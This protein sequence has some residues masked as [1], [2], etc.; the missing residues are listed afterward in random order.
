MA[1]DLGTMI[2][3][4]RWLGPWA[5]D[6]APTR[7]RR[8]EETLEAGGRAMRIA[9]H[10]PRGA[11]R[12]VW[13]V[14]PG[15]HFLGPGDPRLD[16]FCRVLAAAGFVVVAPYLPDFLSLVIAERASADLAVAF[17]RAEEIARAASLP[18]PALFSISF[19]SL[20]AAAVAASELGARARALVLFGGFCDFAET[21][22][23]SITGRASHEGVTLEVEHDP[24]NAPVVHL[25]MLPLM[26]PELD[27]ARLAAAWRAMV[28]RTWGK[29]E[30][31]VGRAREP[32]ALDV[33]RAH[34]LEG[35]LRE[36]FLVGCGLAPGGEAL[37]EAALS[38]LG[39][40]YA[41]ADPRPHLARVKPPVA[42]VHGR[43][44]DV[45][46]YFEAY[47]IRAALPAGHPHG[48]H[49]TGMYGHTGSALPSPRAL[50]GELATLARVLR[51]LAS[52]RA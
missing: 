37:V 10:E 45:I 22:R 9:V 31:K 2:A 12:A 8:R 29:P 17:E 48:L 32:F 36:A 41:W 21:V 34:G 3:L 44:D 25:H 1:G 46:P 5:G 11:A 19:G 26:P 42:I 23:Y 18:P 43:G 24:L 28:E 7:T 6:R 51:V 50:A 16:R 13:V 14:A 49:V 20:P 33:A 30:L 38:R 27:R 39:A 40:A 47:K 4:G 15:L 52:Q 35:P